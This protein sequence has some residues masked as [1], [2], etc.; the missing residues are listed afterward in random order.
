MISK[1][2]HMEAL[3][4]AR[5]GG[6]RARVNDLNA[7]RDVFGEQVEEIVK[8]NRAKKLEADWQKI[9]QDHGR[10]DIQGIK[11]TLWK[12]VL[13]EGIEY[14]VAD[15]Q[16]G[17]QFKVTRCPFAEMAH[18]LDAADWGYICFCEDDPAM[19]AGFNPQM[20]FRRTK[21]L[22]QGHDCCDHFYFMKAE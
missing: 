9:A 3:Q 5:K 20:G 15:T 21:T 6:F 7:L 14:E 8:V 19:V 22:M 13:D 10:N 11:D 18:E 1:E 12:W 4:Q 16:E 17:T 2:E